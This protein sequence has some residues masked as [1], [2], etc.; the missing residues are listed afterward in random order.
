MEGNDSSNH[1]R[2]GVAVGGA[3]LDSLQEHMDTEPVKHQ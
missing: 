2:V 3:L 1:M